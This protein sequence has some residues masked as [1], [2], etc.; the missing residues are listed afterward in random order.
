[1]IRY[2]ETR[3]AEQD[4]LEVIRFIARDDPHAARLFLSEV[5]ERYQQ[6]SANIEMG[7]SRPDLAPDI[8]SFPIGSYL[9]LYRSTRDGIVIA[10]FLH[11]AR[12][13]PT[14]L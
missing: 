6:L 9:I 12:D 14:L 11:S 2:H 1:M 13:I 4:L 10:R 7:R 5:R 3:L 8:R